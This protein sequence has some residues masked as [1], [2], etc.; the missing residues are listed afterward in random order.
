[1]DY[2][3]YLKYQDLTLGIEG[4]SAIS[5]GNFGFEIVFTERY[6]NAESFYDYIP[7]KFYPGRAI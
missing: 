6:Y 4:I 3:I 5:L 2:M 1:M 7:F